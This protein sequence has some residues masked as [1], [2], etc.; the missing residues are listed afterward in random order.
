M[1][2]LA[3]AVLG[4][5]LLLVPAGGAAAQAQ[6]RCDKN[7]KLT[8]GVIENKVSGKRLEKGDRISRESYDLFTAKTKAKVRYQGVV[9]SLLR[10]SDFG[11]GCFGRSVQQGGI[12]PR[13]ILRKG[14]VKLIAR[15]GK[16]GAV[17]T[18]EAMADPF[19]DR[20]MRIIVKRRLKK[21][22]VPYGKTRVNRV[23]GAGYVNLTPYVGPRPGTCRQ[24]DGGTFASSAGPGRA[25][26][27]GYS[28]S[29]P[30]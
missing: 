11:L 15:A 3:I 6:N 17:S 22:S 30:R 7:A 26:Y 8:S 23:R 29:S 9:Y 10:G 4:T 18:Y 25:R 16:P 24:V 12:Y 1:R 13:L 2:G 27:R 19:A 20:A 14:W 5:A 21:P 28:A